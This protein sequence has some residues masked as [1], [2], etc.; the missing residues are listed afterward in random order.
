MTVNGARSSG[1][2]LRMGVPQGSIL[3]PFLFLVYINDL[4]QLVRNK[5]DLVLFADD[6]SLL[7]KIYR[8]QN[9]YDDVNAAISSVVDWFTANNLLL[10]EKK[11]KC[12]K[13]VLPNVKP[14]VSSIKIKDELLD[15]EDSTI[16]LGMSLDAKLQW[17]S[18]ISKLSNRLSSATF[19]VKKI[20]TLTNEDTARLVYFSYF[21]CLMSYGILLWGHAADANCVFILQ[22]RA[23]RAIYN[24]GNRV[25]LR[26]KFG[27]SGILTFA[28]QYIYENLLYVQKNKHQFKKY[29]DIHNRNTRN[30]NKLVPTITRLHKISKSFIGQCVRFYNKI[31]LDFQIL[32]L[33]QFKSV[34]KRKLCKK[35]YYKISDY[36]EDLNPWS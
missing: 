36:L 16:F 28:S 4:P 20:R 6:T 9:N 18:H 34:I 7:F 29:C 17:G 30:K 13:F 12:V 3:G 14:V 1:S 8:Q 26:D 23:V 32:P 25:S 11:T 5:H 2:K 15:F 10:N 24:L 31:P 33:N 22:K 21:H 19:A 27:E 35:G